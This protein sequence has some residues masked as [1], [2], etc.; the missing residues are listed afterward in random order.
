MQ[1]KR[2]SPCRRTLRAEGPVYG[3]LA[4][5]LND[6][7]TRARRPLTY[8]ELA[9]QLGWR[10]QGWD[11]HDVG[12]LA[13]SV[14]AFH[15]EV[16]GQGSWQ[17][18]SAVTLQRGEFGELSLDVGHLHGATVGSIYKVYPPIGFA[19][20]DAPGGCVVVTELT[21]TTARWKRASSM[22]WPRCPTT[23]CRHRDA[24]SWP[25]P[26]QGR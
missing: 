2:K 11:W 14:H 10:Y 21:P 7:L 15:N 23:C 6:V 16:L 18:R 24:V 1:V 20:D 26:R 19:S 22:M 9:Q 13:G 25:S 5:T 3:R 17:N 8:L 4:Y 12:Q